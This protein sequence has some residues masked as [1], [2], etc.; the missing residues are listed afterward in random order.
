MPGTVATFYRAPSGNGLAQVRLAEPH[1]N[2]PGFNNQIDVDPVTLKTYRMNGGGDGI[3]RTISMFHSTLLLRDFGGRS[4]VGWLGVA[5]LVLGATGLVNWWPRPR[6]WTAAFA[7][8]EMR[9]ALAFIA[10]CMA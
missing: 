3:L 5:M 8:P 1:H 4:L 7:F 2:A 10:T 6:R 9:A